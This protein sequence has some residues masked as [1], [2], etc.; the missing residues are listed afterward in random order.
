MTKSIKE[1]SGFYYLLTE[2]QL[3][4]FGIEYNPQEVSNKIKD[5]S[6]AHNI[7][8]IVG[9][10]S[11]MCRFYCDAFIEYLLAGKT[12]LDYTYLFFP[13]DYKKNDKII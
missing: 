1:H 7:F 8:R 6:F 10:N 11:I 9:N 3:C 5:K 4:T 13:N 2:I 12:L